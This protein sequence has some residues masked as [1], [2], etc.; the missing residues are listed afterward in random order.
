[1]GRHV[2][3]RVPQR[4]DLFGF[5]RSHREGVRSD[6]SMFECFGGRWIEPREFVLLAERE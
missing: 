5:H 2:R 3:Q 6:A 4:C 1:M